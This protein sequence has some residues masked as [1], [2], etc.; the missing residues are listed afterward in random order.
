MKEKCR[1]VGIPF[2][3]HLG[4]VVYR[5]FRACDVDVFA[6]IQYLV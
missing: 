1:H 2:I 3:P 4:Q 5:Q 6:K